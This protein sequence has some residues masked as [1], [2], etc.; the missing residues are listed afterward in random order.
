MLAG[1]D[2]SGWIYGSLLVSG[3]SGRK[4][5]SMCIEITLL[6]VWGG[7]V[8]YLWGRHLDL[9]QCP[10]VVRSVLTVLTS[11]TC[12]VWRLG[13]EIII[14]HC[15]TTSDVSNHM[16]M[17]PCDTSPR[18][19]IAHPIA[20]TCRCAA[21]IKVVF[22]SRSIHSSDFFDPR[23]KDEHYNTTLCHHHH[24][25]DASKSSEA[26]PLLSLCPEATKAVEIQ[27]SSAV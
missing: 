13:S 5:Q 16:L 21:D 6:T 8:K 17:L 25:S 19:F 26:D 9:S 1:G 20:I 2:G 12:L 3:F 11:S 7:T 23:N 15:A 18:S 22:T 14:T 24:S 10:V 4:V 27:V